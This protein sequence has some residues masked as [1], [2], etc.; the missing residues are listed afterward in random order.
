MKLYMNDGSP[1][2]RKVRIFA[3]EKGLSDQIQ[4]VATAVSPVG[5]NDALANANPLLKIPVLITDSGE[6]IYDSGVI[7]EY[8]DTLHQRTK[9]FPV[10]GQERLN[11]LRRQALCDG[12][13]DALVLCRYEQA[14]RPAN[15]RWDAWIE[16]QMLKVHGGLA[17]LEGEVELW[18]ED[19]KIAQMS[20]VCVLG[21]LDF[22]FAEWD[23]RRTHPRLARWNDSFSTRH[24]VASTAPS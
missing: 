7:C 18:R 4:E 1:F 8:L 19:F 6:P 2:A 13:L 24:S 3:S 14:I 21:Y 10:A 9:L 5:A 17:E 20:A 11:T 16:G 22:R 12:I 15:L 23:W